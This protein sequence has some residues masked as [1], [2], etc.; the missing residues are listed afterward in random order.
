MINTISVKSV[1]IPKSGEN[2]LKITAWRVINAEM[3]VPLTRRSRY[4]T[5][6]LV[7]FSDW[8][9]GTG[10]FWYSQSE[11]VVY[12]YCKIRDYPKIN[13]PVKC[14]KPEI[15]CQA[16]VFSICYVWREMRLLFQ[17]GSFLSF[18]SSWQ[19][20][21]KTGRMNTENES[22]FVDKRSMANTGWSRMFFLNI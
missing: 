17:G 18:K 8:H 12:S 19:H 15:C 20:W 9:C 10:G 16:V 22:Q 2:C 13:H 11:G 6:L 3:P 1:S 21:K 14:N 4:Q 5:C 7:I